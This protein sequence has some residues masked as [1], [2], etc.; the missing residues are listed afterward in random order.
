MRRLQKLP[1][2]GIPYRAVT[3]RIVGVD[4]VLQV[5][6]RL[7]QLDRDET[8]VARL[9]LPGFCALLRHCAVRFGCRVA[10]L[11]LVLVGG[12]SKRRAVEE[13]QFLGEL[14]ER[15]AQDRDAVR[16]EFRDD[17]DDVH[18][19]GE[20]R[21][22]LRRIGVVVLDERDVVCPGAVRDK[23]IVVACLVR[24]CGGR[25]R[26]L[27]CELA[28]HVAA[29]EA[30]VLVLVQ[31]VPLLAEVRVE[32]ELL[33][34]RLRGVAARR[35]HIVR[36][37]RRLVPLGEGDFRHR[38]GRLSAHDHHGRAEVCR[39]KRLY[40]ETI[41]DERRVVRDLVAPFKVVFHIREDQRDFLL[42]RCLDGLV[43]VCARR[44]LHFLR[45]KRVS[46]C[47]PR[48]VLRRILH[49]V[50]HAK[51]LDR[52]ALGRGEDVEFEVRAARLLLHVLADKVHRRLAAFD[53]HVEAV[54][55]RRREAGEVV[56]AAPE[57]RRAGRTEHEAVF[58]GEARIDRH[59][60]CR[61]LCDRGIYE[62][63]NRRRRPV[64]D[65]LVG[66]IRVADRHGRG[67]PHFG[68][69]QCRLREHLTELQR[70]HVRGP[71]HRPLPADRVGDVRDVS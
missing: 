42:A 56:L 15:V 16:I 55:D 26:S 12:G 47:V 49:G 52:R 67:V 4:I 22:D 64:R 7:A 20:T 30:D 19:H 45:G 71:V 5:R 23:R 60:L 3:E 53:R 65:A 32:P 13:R 54:G 61:G 9:V 24:V 25:L 8:C 70:G 11:E 57:E 50:E 68:E 66:R 39:R 14:V 43:V 58:V 6:A 33:V 41:L 36:L 59:R 51:R 29:A 62:L 48:I 17:L 21:G 44:G 1:R 10:P 28:L 63:D 27:P 31:L 34:F 46:R 69:S 40:D 18:L 37:V 35:A 38:V 2:H